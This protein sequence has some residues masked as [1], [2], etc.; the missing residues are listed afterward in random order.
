VDLFD[1]AEIKFMQVRAPER[2]IS[3]RE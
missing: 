1:E 3:V 2:I